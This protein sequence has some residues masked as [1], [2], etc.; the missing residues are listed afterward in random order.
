MKFCLR[1]CRLQAKQKPV[2]EKVEVVGAIGIHNQGVGDATKLQETLEVRGAPR[3]TR[4]FES[5][6]SSNAAQADTADDIL[7]ADAPRGAST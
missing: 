3:Q 5:E 4:D 2:V 7:E 1:H 6:D